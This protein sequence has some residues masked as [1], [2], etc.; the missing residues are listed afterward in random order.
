[1]SRKK[2]MYKPVTLIEKVCRW[3]LYAIMLAFTASMIHLRWNVYPEL[4]KQEFVKQVWGS[5]NWVYLL[6]I[7]FILVL[8]YVRSNWSAFKEIFEHEKR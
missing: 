3:T 7:I 6:G 5:G 8:L 4:T 1:M 2:I